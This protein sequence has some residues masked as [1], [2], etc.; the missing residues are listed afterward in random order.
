MSELTSSLR[1][2]SVLIRRHGAPLFAPLDETVAPGT[3]LT[4]MGPSGVGKSTLLA[5]IAGHLDRSAFSLEGR[6]LIGDRDVAPLPPHLRGVGLLFQ[7]DLLFHHL[8]VEGNLLFGLLS[9]QG[10]TRAERRATVAA[11]LADA[12][13]AGLGPRSIETLSGGQRAR[14]ALLRVL[15]SR[16]RVLLL[17]EPFSKLDAAL[18]GQIRDLVLKTAIARG[19]P[20]VLVTHDPADA[21]AAAALGG[22]TVVLAPAPAG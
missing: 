21:A 2:E 7:D 17:D 6:I 14:V 11:A 15:L 9:A 5:A 20:T 19:L 10:S 12:G 1:L 16:P 13:L 18:K 4:L 8:T 3:V 22:K